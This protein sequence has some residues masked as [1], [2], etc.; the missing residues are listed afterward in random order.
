MERK[1]SWARQSC[2]VVVII[3]ADEVSGMGHEA[4]EFN[5]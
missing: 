1:L 3:I 5:L 2:V 4:F